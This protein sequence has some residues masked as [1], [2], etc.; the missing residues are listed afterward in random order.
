MMWQDNCVPG[1]GNK[2]KYKHNCPDGQRIEP[3][4]KKEA[5]PKKPI[6]RPRKAPGQALKPVTM[7][8]NDEQ[9]AKY[10]LV[11][12]QPLRDWLDQL[13]WPPAPAADQRR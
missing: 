12:P 6:G 1:H 13:P 8:L 4:V 9:H 5:P 10:L 11:G 7:R 3:C 2:M